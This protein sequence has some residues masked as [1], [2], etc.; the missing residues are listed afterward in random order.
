MAS[1]QNLYQCRLC[2]KRTPTRVNIFGGDFPKMLEILTSIKV[3]ENDG[4]PKYSC[5]KCAQDVKS[6]LIIKKRIIKAHKYLVESLRKRNIPSTSNQKMSVQAQ[7]TKRAI[8]K[9]T[10]I[11][12][13]DQSS[14]TVASKCPTDA[15][16]NENTS[17]SQNSE[18]L[19]EDTTPKVEVKLEVFDDSQNSNDAS[20][21]DENSGD[22]LN[23]IIQKV[24]SRKATRDQT[25]Y[26]CEVC[27]I[28]FSNKP[29]YTLHSNKHKKTKCE[30]CNRVTRSDNFRKHL[31]LHSSGPSVCNLCGATCKNIESLRGHMFYQHRS[32]SDAYVCEECG[33]RFKI[34]YKFLL[35]KTKVHTGIRN[36]KCETCGKA[37]FTKGNL[38]THDKMTHKKLRPHICEFC[39]TGFSSPYALKTHKRQHTNEKPYVCDQCNEGFRQKVSLRSHLKS[40]HGIEEAK[41]SICSECG[42]G[43]ATNYALS[44]HQRLHTS[45]KCEV[46]SESFAGQEYLDNHM[47]EAHG[48]ESE[49]RE[50]DGLPKYACVQCSLDVKSALIT[51]RRIITA[52]KY[53]M[54]KL[55]KQSNPSTS[56]QNMTVH[57]NTIP[58]K[59][60]KIV[61]QNEPRAT[62]HL[63]E[64][65]E[66]NQS[67][68]QNSANLSEFITPKIE[69]KQEALEDYENSN[70]SCKAGFPIPNKSQKIVIQNEPRATKHLE[71]TVEDNQSEIQNSANLSEFITPK[72]EIK[73]EALEDYENSNS[74]CKAG[75]PSEI[76]DKMDKER[77]VPTTFTCE[78]CNESFP[79]KTALSQHFEKHKKTKCEICNKLIRT[80]N[81]KKHMLVHSSGPSV[82]SL[83]GATSKNLDSLRSHIFRQHH[84]RSGII[85]EE[86]GVKFKSRY[87]LLLH[88]SQV[89]TGVRK[90]K[91]ETCGKAFFTQNTLN[92]HDRM[93][94]KK[95]RPHICEFCRKGFSTRHALK[96]H[97]RQHTNEKPFVC[98][99]CNKGFRQKVSLR[100]HLKS[101]HGIEEAKES[102][103]S[104]CGR[105]FATNHALGIHQRLHTS[106][107]CEVCSES[108]ADQEYLSNHMKKAHGVDSEAENVRSALITK[109][110]IIKAHK[111]LIEHLGKRNI[112]STSDQKAAS[113]QRAVLRPTKLPKSEKR[114]EAEDTK[115]PT[116]VFVN[117]VASD[118]QNICE[119]TSPKVE[120]KIEQLDESQNSNDASIADEESRDDFINEINDKDEVNTKIPLVQVSYTCQECNV[121]FAKRKKYNSHCE[122]HK[123]NQCDICKKFIRRDNFKKHLLLHAAGPT[124]CNVC[125]V[126][127]KNFESLRSH[128]YQRHSGRSDCVCEECGAKFSGKY[129][130]LLHKTKVHT[131]VK[132]FKCV[133]CGKAF[134]TQYFLNNHDRLTHKK[135][136][137]YVCEF[138]GTGFS[139][140][141]ALKTHNRQHTNERPFVCDQC[142]E[143]FR[144]RVSLRSHLKSKHGIEEPKE[145]ICSECGKGFA[146]VFALS[147]HQRLHASIKCGVCSESFAGQE[148]LDNH[149]KEAHE[150]RENDG[151]P[152]YACLKCALDVKSALITKRRIIKAHKYLIEQLGKR[153]NPSTS[154]QK[155]QSS[156]K[157]VL[158]P[159]NRRSEL[160][161]SESATDKN[162]SDSKSSQNPS[163]CITPKVEIKV[164]V[165]DES[166]NSNDASIADKES[167]PG[168]T[169]AVREKDEVNIKT[170]REQITYTCNECNIS[171]NKKTA[172]SQHY[173]KHK[174]TKCDL[175]GKMIRSGNFKKHL[176]VHSSG[177]SVCNLCGATYKNMESLRSH[178]Y[179]EHQNR[180]G[181][182]CEECGAK[183]RSRYFLL[184][185]KAKIHTGERKFK[186]ETCG[187][188]FFTK[189]FLMKHDRM[190]HK[191]LRPHVC[192]FCG[193]G[194]SSPYALKT[195]KRQHTN[196]KP[197]VCDQCSEGF[198]QRVS[199]RS[200]LKSK[201]GI[202]EAK[203]CIC[204]ECGKG[205]ATTFALDVH[206]RLHG[207][208]KCEVCSES[209]A[210]QEYLDN[211]MKE[212]HGVDGEVRENDGLPRYSCLKCALDVKSALITKKRIIK[213]YKYL[214]AN[215]GKQNIA[216]T[217]DQKA[218]SSKRA[219]IKPDRPSELI[220]AEA[221]GTSESQNSEDPSES[222]TPKVEI[223]HE[224]LDESQNSSDA[225]IADGETGSC[226]TSEVTDKDKVH[227]KTITYTCEECNIS[228]TKKTAHTL[229]C[230][231]HK[232]TKCDICGKMIRSSNMKQHL[233]VHTSG[234]SV[235]KF[236]SATCKNVHSLR[237]H[238]YR[239]HRNKN[240]YVCEECGARFKGNY[241][242]LLH[243]TKSHTGVK[244]FK[245]E[246]CGKAFFTKYFLNNHDRMTH[247][248]LRPH[249][250]EFCGTGFSSPYALKTHKRQHTNEKPFVCDQCDEG[251]RQKVSLRSHLKSKHGIE[252]AKECICSECGKGFA[253][254]FALD[255]HQRLHGSVKCEVCSESFAGQGYLDNH[256]KEAHAV[257]NEIREN[258]GLPKYSCKQCAL[259]VKSA[260][261]IKR[262]IIK[263]H[264]YLMQHL[265]KRKATVLTQS[266]KK[267]MLKP[268]KTAKPEKLAEPSQAVATKSS[269][270]LYP[271]SAS[272]NAENLSE[273]TTPKVEIKEEVLDQTQN[274]TPQVEIKLEVLDASLPNQ[275]SSGSANEIKG[276][277]NTKKI[278]K[279][280]TYTCT[281]C[282]LAKHKKTNCHICDKLIRSDN[283]NKHLLVHNTGPSVCSLC[284]VSYKNSE[285]LRSH[286]SK[287]H[288]SP[289]YVCEECGKRFKIRYQFMLH[290]KK[291]HTGTRN[292]KC[293]TCGKA[294]FTRESLTIHDKMTHQKLR[295]YIC[296][297][298]G[299]GF[300]SRYALRTHKRQHTNEKP[301]VCDQCNEGFR[302]KVS[303][304]SHLKSKH[305]I[306]EPKES[307]CSDCGKG[308]AT[309]FALS[310]HQRLHASM[311][312]EVCSESFAGQEYLDNHMKEAHGDDSEV[313][314]EK[315][316]ILRK[317]VKENDGMPK[318]SC[319][320]CAQDVK[321]AL[322][323]KKRI[324]RSYNYLTEAIQRPSISSESNQSTINFAESPGEIIPNESQTIE[325]PC[326]T[327]KAAVTKSVKKS[328][329][330]PENLNEDILSKVEVKLESQNSNDASVADESACG[331]SN[332]TE[333]KDNRKKTREK[334]NYTCKL[335]N[336]SFSNK[337]TYSSHY[338]KHKKT[339]CEICN[340]S[341]RSDNFK[342]HLIVHSS[343]P[344][345]VC[346]LCGASCK[347]I[348]SLQGH[349][350][351]QHRNLNAYVCEECG[352]KFNSRYMF[353]LHKNRLHTGGARTI[354]CE[355]CGKM[356]FTKY[357]LKKH[358]RMTH[359]KLRPHICEF[360]GTG[361]SSPYA[362]RTHKRQHTNEKPFVC[363]HCNERFTVKVSLKSH[364]KSKH[365]IEEAKE[366]ICPDCG[367]GFAT[368]Y[369]LSVH[370]RSHKSV[371]CELCSESFAGLEYMSNHMR[372]AHGMGGDE[373]QDT[374]QNDEESSIEKEQL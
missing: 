115:S 127:F 268:T 214:I 211:H 351:Y 355:T 285:S 27:N 353:L 218:Q 320:Q 106:M 205:F 171:F 354:K 67:E 23:D 323:V 301:F 360:C 114:D 346:K 66:D 342:K 153:H 78:V 109:R 79:R 324:I 340:K 77:T 184:L 116:A 359:K 13:P 228:F 35:H 111:Y 290:K 266:S 177:P 349:M 344:P 155:A 82:C 235:C 182:V 281:D 270:A 41:E 244:K 273:P 337:R 160:I 276:K 42:R 239:Q 141:F 107:K 249:V 145:S 341:V 54:E 286:I 93:T 330:D 251:F 210:G 232:K 45:M 343:G 199:L 148:Y 338:E 212:A 104:D 140:R 372:E 233:T 8:L 179:R 130:L 94:H 50:N 263:A 28:S 278:D 189:H 280:T 91:C 134:F 32:S 43:F 64:T 144:Q 34:K 242:L 164:E 19:S 30:I 118:S 5:L 80:G 49:V 325:T 166:Q 110:R 57:E 159:T 90:F 76:G 6:A 261:I 296:E 356:Y 322:I 363:D 238:I 258:D 253:T 11:V 26:T 187:K 108:F 252:E 122:M 83:C 237:S 68:I 154:D 220:K 347:N 135:I 61:I 100:G 124:V 304:R 14:Q 3:R 371:K 209:F 302:Q 70:S 293:E 47:K 318:Y 250:C 326:T 38:M 370:Q 185:H 267:A 52:H 193:T 119:T 305:G 56:N 120:V 207:S 309:N 176:I 255:V 72:I 101:K 21:A 269:A 157:T 329:P 17:D 215:L 200:H 260:L 231:R 336:M 203:E 97:R 183:F 236:C 334:V 331:M 31:M 350:F 59:S 339:K 310:I 240:S 129:Y 150:V 170:I 248:K 300:S 264:K 128:K 245:C 362:L 289:H 161:K 198:R 151:L 143:G 137:P 173:E 146:T 178:I 246:T 257:D 84:N 299:T 219:V 174:K 316:R 15:L 226:S 62:K 307:I 89:H 201:H 283:F 213:A 294:F 165:S 282:N 4:L 191:K 241:A 195:H 345:A 20:I 53:F 332:K 259:D 117:E 366:S 348:A 44:I 217:S 81:F 190:T 275:E 12:I 230:D 365:G 22:F 229:H 319:K 247:K 295:P 208:M 292:F 312:C 136:R 69:I 234:P 291:V 196:E 92:R 361:L 192:E 186:C 298:C 315:V 39:G 374:E 98:D 197:F 133:T 152:Q 279:K 10:K 1:T 149:M 321:S 284:G 169:S 46:C 105:C 73:Q 55:L 87:Y 181:W 314:E 313:N 58:N 303:L 9:P 74:S 180:S 71:E 132:N 224:V 204:S 99:Q 85:C 274:I 328:Y 18:S 175:C 317:T 37:F 306:E 7:S 272:Q 271:T 138:C 206:Q 335:C 373:D 24:M 125:G 112:P 223:K 86:C 265:G 367:K 364:L 277:A 163:E 369:A 36:F 25:T 65:V 288:N 216:S 243:Q 40:K 202:E 333:E 147:I 60:Q 262:R 167:D 222:I 16:V 103:C 357:D 123:K 126:T 121:S 308:F 162:T 131:G 156:K 188:A 287:H 225:S 172:Y 29:A 221:G 158:K 75:F 142:N 256:M 168:S 88:K 352:A 48:G 95:M 358:D 96:T 311:K 194:F 51:K 368:D 254:A 102:V 63:E 113:S 2:L 327:K 139:S 227:T 297:F 33:K